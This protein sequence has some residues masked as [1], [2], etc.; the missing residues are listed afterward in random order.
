MNRDRQL[1]KLEQRVGIGLATGSPEEQAAQRDAEFKDRY[2]KLV[3]T[4]SEIKAWLWRQP[5]RR[6]HRASLAVAAQLEQLNQPNLDNPAFAVNSVEVL[7]MYIAA[8]PLGEPVRADVLE[9]YRLFCIRPN[10]NPI[11]RELNQLPWHRSYWFAAHVYLFQMG[12]LEAPAM[13][14]DIA[15]GCYPL[16]CRWRMDT[17]AIYWGKR[18][19]YFPETFESRHTWPRLTYRLSDGTVIPYGSSE[20]IQ[21]RFSLEDSKHWPP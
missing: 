8:T 20:E 16:T 4:P 9:R 6:A 19:L 11:R 13:R 12:G 7:A 10:P 5:W 18:E 14:R 21:A 17:T 15:A 2:F 1:G 3:L